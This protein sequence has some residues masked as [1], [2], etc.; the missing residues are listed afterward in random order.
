M[1][2][3]FFLQLC[4]AV[5]AI[6]AQA[7]LTVTG[8]ALG[9][10][11]TPGATNDVWANPPPAGAVFDRWVGDTGVLAD[12]YAWHTTATMPSGSAAITATYKSSPAWSPSTYI[13]NDLAPTDP[14]AI[15]LMYYFPPNPVGVIFRFH[16]SGGSAATLFA[17]V[18]DFTFARDAVAA[19][20]AI[21]SL[22]ST[23]RVN[24]Q[25][26]DTATAANVDVVNVQAAINYFIGLGLMA[27]STPKFCTG[28]S[29]GG[30]F[31]PKA[32]Y[33]LGFQGC[34]I[35][36]AAGAP[37]ALFNIMTVPTI[38]SLAQADDLYDHTNF[39]PASNAEL[40]GLTNRGVRG[41]LR[42][43]GP[44]PV[45]ARRFLRI[46]YF[47]A[48]DSQTIYDSLKAGGFLDAQDYLIADP[49]TSGWVSALPAGFLPYQSDI[50]DQLECC[51]SGH[52][53]YSDFDNKALQFFGALRPPV[54]GRGAIRAIMRQP[55]G[56]M[57]LT[58][59]ADAGQDYRVQASPDLAT[60]T[61]VFTSTDSGGTFDFTDTTTSNNPRRFYRT[62]SS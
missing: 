58:V 22:D 13:L 48:A 57:L 45:Y 40:A 19:G 43:N 59:A 52:Q 61:T 6:G 46:P 54:A 17:K 60:W 55:D 24:K 20:Y 12:L 15:R 47:T 3:R 21:A 25:W 36:C 56:S 42:E 49:A 37:G 9:P 27:A 51:Y 29:D 28:M 35:W 16:G 4:L 26:D 23:D 14:N 38:W 30:G 1:K 50:E 34:G 18:E 31:A 39:L 2:Y 7:A 32:A 44:S 62:V 11:L 8:G 5:A 10:Q 53:F 33:F 41:E